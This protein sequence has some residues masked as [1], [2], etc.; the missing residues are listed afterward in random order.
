MG[1]KKVGENEVDDRMVVV[2][3]T[4]IQDGTPPGI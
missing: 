2:D 4:K 3:R 1:E